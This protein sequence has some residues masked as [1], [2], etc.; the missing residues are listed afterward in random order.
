MN[1]NLSEENKL[2]PID[3]K[4]GFRQQRL[5]LSQSLEDKVNPQSNQTLLKR[6]HP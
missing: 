1:T 3:R 4:A 6:R 2:D 5:A